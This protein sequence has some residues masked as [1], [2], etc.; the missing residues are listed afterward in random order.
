MTGDECFYLG[1]KQK[2][3]QLLWLVVATN[4]HIHKMLV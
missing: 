2:K 4:S 3:N 1:G